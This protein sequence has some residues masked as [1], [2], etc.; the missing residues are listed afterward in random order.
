MQ[1]NEGDPIS[2]HH[3]ALFVAAVL[4]ELIILPSSAAVLSLLGDAVRHIVESVA[5]INV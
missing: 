1:L 2:V 3:S 5:W 4:A